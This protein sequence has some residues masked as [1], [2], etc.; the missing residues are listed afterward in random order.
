[1]L[2]LP[3]KRHTPGQISASQPGVSLSS[4]TLCSTSNLIAN[5]RQTR[6]G[7]ADLQ[8]AVRNYQ[9]HLSKVMQTAD[10]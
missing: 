10:F 8:T 7:A 6:I 4:K 1:M 9:K 3:K 2:D 5:R